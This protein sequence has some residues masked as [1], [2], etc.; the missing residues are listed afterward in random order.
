MN[1][2]LGLTLTGILSGLS[3]GIVGGG[4]EILIVPLLTMFGLLKSLKTRI[5]TSLFMLLPPIGYFAAMK[6]KKSG[7]V[8]VKAALYMAL[9]FTIFAT[10]SSNYSLDMDSDILRKIFGVFT[11]LSGIYIIYA[12]EGFKNK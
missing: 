12:K 1:Y 10:I 2:L 4:A 7:N 8:D 9:I 5:G 6:F 3:A 11:I